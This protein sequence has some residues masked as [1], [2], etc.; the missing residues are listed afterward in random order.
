MKK[1]IMH[2][3]RFHDWQDI[4]TFFAENAEFTRQ[5]CTMCP[6]TRITRLYLGKHENP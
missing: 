3:L 5:E 4:S 2:F 6:K 1:K